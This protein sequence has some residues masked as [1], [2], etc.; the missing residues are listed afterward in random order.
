MIAV[1]DGN[2]TFIGYSALVGQ[3]DRFS[4]DPVVLPVCQGQWITSVP[5]TLTLNDAGTLAIATLG[6]FA[7]AWIFRFLYRQILNR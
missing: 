1:C 5:L 2:I 3:T 7:L 6:L 4:T